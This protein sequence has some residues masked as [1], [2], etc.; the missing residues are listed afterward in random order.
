MPEPDD[1]KEP[2]A[3]VLWARYSQLAFILPAAV[4]VGLLLGKLGDY[5]FHTH[6]L[7]LAGIILGAIAGFVDLI[8]TVTKNKD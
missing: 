7:L 4:V 3:P 6:W 2:S 5:L 8:R 1:N